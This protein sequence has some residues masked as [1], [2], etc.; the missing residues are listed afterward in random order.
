MQVETLFRRYANW[1][2]GGRH[3]SLEDFKTFWREQQRPKKRVNGEK[4]RE[5]QTTDEAEERTRRQKACASSSSWGH[6]WPPRA[7][8][9]TAGSGGSAAS[10][11]A[12]RADTSRRVL[13]AHLPIGRQQ[14]PPEPT[15]TRRVCP[16]CPS[17]G[18]K[19]R[20]AQARG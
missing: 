18:A 11:H 12:A 15:L 3:M 8:Q 16:F 17:T 1:G 14:A 9:T 20:A 19:A 5:P 13:R 2:M 6:S 4:E 7:P 10:Q